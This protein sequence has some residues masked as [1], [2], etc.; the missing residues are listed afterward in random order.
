MRHRFHN[1]REVKAAI[2]EQVDAPSEQKSWAAWNDEGCLKK[3]GKGLTKNKTSQGVLWTRKEWRC[4][5][6]AE[7]KS[8]ERKVDGVKAYDSNIEM[9]LMMID[10]AVEGN[11]EEGEESSNGQGVLRLETPADRGRAENC[12]TIMILKLFTFLLASVAS[13]ASE[14]TLESILNI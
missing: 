13:F 9:M 5:Y 10:V 6:M 11:W 7:I 8:K 12:C 2:P 1:R 14:S 4:P 3:E